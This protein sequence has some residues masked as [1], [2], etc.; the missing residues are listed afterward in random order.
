MKGYRRLRVGE[1]IREGDVASDKSILVYSIGHKVYK[2]VTAYRPLTKK[3]VE[4]WQVFKQDF[5][6]G[7][8]IGDSYHGERAR[9]WSL[10]DAQ[11]ICKAV[12]EYLGEK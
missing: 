5:R 8:L 10:K 1:V 7:W 12:N 6:E 2:G 9:V 4:K 11:L 3:P